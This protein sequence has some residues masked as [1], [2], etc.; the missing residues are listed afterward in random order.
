[1][2]RETLEAGTMSERNSRQCLAWINSLRLTLGDLGLKAAPDVVPPSLSESAACWVPGALHQP[3][4]F[5][6]DWSDPCAR[7]SRSWSIRRLMH[8]SINAGAAACMVRRNGHQRR[9]RHAQLHSSKVSSALTLADGQGKLLHS[10]AEMISD[11][12]PLRQI[13]AP[14]VTPSPLH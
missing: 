12:L 8:A 11:E 1:M 6:P 9:Q 4:G 14:H 2:D 13:A 7:T 5:T 3:F 10:P